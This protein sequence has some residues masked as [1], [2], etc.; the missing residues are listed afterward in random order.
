RTFCF[1]NVALLENDEKDEEDM[2]L[3]SGDEIS[4]I[5]V[6]SNFHSE[7]LTKE[8]KGSR[9]TDQNM[10]IQI[11]LQ[12]SLDVQKSLLEDKTYQIDSE[13][14]AS[15]DLVCSEGENSNSAEQDSYSNFQV[16]HSQ[17]NMSHQFSHFNVLT[18][19]TFLGTP[20]ALSSS[21]SQESENYFLSAYTQSLD[22]EKSSSPL[23]WGKSDSSRPYSKEK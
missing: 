9:G 12:S 8:T 4:Q 2:S 5:E 3:D 17:L 14:R 18:H 19:Q 15:I 7:I 13:E 6:C 20:Y 1:L 10:N 16:Y 11:Q 21:Q 22:R 23:N